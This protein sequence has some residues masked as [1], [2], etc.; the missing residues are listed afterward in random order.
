MRKSTEVKRF[1]S[2]PVTR[3]VSVIIS[4]SEKKVAM[5]NQPPPYV[6]GDPSAPVTGGYQQVG[7]QP[8]NYGATPSTTAYQQGVP[9]TATAGTPVGYYII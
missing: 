1:T 2:R 5:S 3:F 8:Q 7:A 6:K 9:Y 4:L